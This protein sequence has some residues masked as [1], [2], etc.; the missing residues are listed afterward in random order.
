MT[1]FKKS[2]IFVAHFDNIFDVMM[3]MF[4]GL[5]SDLLAA[6]VISK[7]GQFSGAE[8]GQFA[9]GI[10]VDL[11]RKIRS[12]RLQFMG[13]GPCGC[14][15]GPVFLNR[16]RHANPSLNYADV[17]GPPDLRTVAHRLRTSGLTCYL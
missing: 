9:S 10:G 8:D 14:S 11:Q 2:Q 12:L 7:K 1:H 16:I 13:T 5:A 6:E 3:T 4:L 17:R 15:C